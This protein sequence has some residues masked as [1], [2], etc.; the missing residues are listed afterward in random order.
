MKTG[1]DLLLCAIEP[2]DLTE[3]VNYE[4]ELRTG[5]TVHLEAAAHVLVAGRL[6]QPADA[7][8]RVVRLRGLEAGDETGARGRSGRTGEEGEA[9][10]GVGLGGGGEAADERAG[11]GDGEHGTVGGDGGLRAVRIIHVEHAGLGELRGSAAVGAV[12]R[13]AFDLGRAMLVRLDEDR[14]VGEF[15]G[16]GGS[17]IRR[18]AG[19]R[20]LGLLGVRERVVARLAATGEAE[21]G[22]AEGRAHEHQELAALDGGDGGGA[23][24]ELAFGAGAELG[25][26]VAL[27]EA[28]PV[29]GTGR[30]AGLGRGVFK[31]FLAH[32]KRCGGLAVAAR[33]ALGRIDLPVVDELRAGGGLRGGRGGLAACGHGARRRTR[34]ATCE[35]ARLVKLVTLKRTRTR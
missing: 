28:A 33:A 20:V 32:R 26:L 25:R 22:E 16:E 2:K 10:A 18:D 24:D 7:D 19:D 14:L 5:R 29:R 21:T 12:A 15:A 1:F 34:A 13:V 30:L 4:R 11:G 9:G 35:R 17:V 27:V 23:V 8:L 3:I 6:H 31:D